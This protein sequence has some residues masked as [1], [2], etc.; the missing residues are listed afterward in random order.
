MN[1]LSL[2]LLLCFYGYWV[3][4]VVWK[5][6][7]FVSI[8]D[9]QMHILLLLLFLWPSKQKVCHFTFCFHWGEMVRT[10]SIDQNGS[11]LEWRRGEQKK[12]HTKQKKSSLVGMI[13][14]FIS[15]VSQNLQVIS[16]GDLKQTLTSLIFYLTLSFS[17]V[18]SYWTLM[19]H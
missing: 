17:P 2:S 19:K 3:K 6:K 14:V 10:L 11:Y 8:L 9:C 1:G 13:S 16:F 15:W 7:I 4:W 18:K 5:L 12:K